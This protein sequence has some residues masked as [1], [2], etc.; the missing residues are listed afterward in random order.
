MSR[1]EPGL[2]ATESRPAGRKSLAQRV[3]GSPNRADFA[4][5]GVVERWVAA[6]RNLSA[7][8]TTEEKSDKRRLCRPYGTRVLHSRLPSD[9]SLG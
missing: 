6:G 4:R 9:E 8:G 7:V 5:I 2:P 1:Y 3:P